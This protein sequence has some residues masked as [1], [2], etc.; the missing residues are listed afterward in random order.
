VS[1][2]PEGWGKLKW[3]KEHLEKAKKEGLPLFKIEV[4]FR[5]AK[6]AG[7]G[8]RA[9]QNWGACSQEVA[10]QLRQIIRDQK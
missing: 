5:Y 9:L 1:C 4:D 3:T 10:A 6:E 7:G 8:T 2:G